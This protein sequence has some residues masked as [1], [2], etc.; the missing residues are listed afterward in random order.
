MA[1]TEKILVGEL[2]LYLNT[3]NK[4]VSEANDILKR[5]GKDT[6]NNIKALSASYTKVAD[7][8]L[9]AAKKIASAENIKKKSDSGS[10]E[11]AEMKKAYDQLVLA[12]RE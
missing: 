9:K 6:D 11:L 4:N 8:I 7:D 2:Y 1:D 10:K 3:L 12:Q 5:I